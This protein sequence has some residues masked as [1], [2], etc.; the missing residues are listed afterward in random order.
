MHRACGANDPACIVHVVSMTPQTG[1]CAVIDSRM[2]KENF[3]FLREFESICK[4]VLPL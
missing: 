1:A 2:H 4:K 3:D